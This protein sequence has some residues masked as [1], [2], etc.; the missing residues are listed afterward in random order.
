MGEPSGGCNLGGAVVTGGM[1]N[2]VPDQTVDLNAEPDFAVT[3]PLRPLALAAAVTLMAYAGATVAVC[4]VTY[5][6]IPTPV[7]TAWT[8]AAG[9]FELAW[10]VLVVTMWLRKPSPR[11]TVQVWASAARFIIIASQ[12]VVALAIWGFFPYLPQAERMMLAGMFVICSPAQIIAAP[13]NVAANR[14]GILASDGS[15]VLWFALHGSGSDPVMDFAMA[16]FAS[17]IG[18]ML[19]ALAGY[20]PGTVAETVSARLAAEQAKAG[21]ERALEAVAEERDAKTRFI[22][23]ASHYLGQPL[24]AASLFFDQTLRAPDPDQRDRAADGVRKAFASADQLISHMLNHLR[25]EADAVD[26]HLTRVALG[27]AM[28]R[29]AAQFGPAASAAGIGIRAV[30]TSKRIRLDR[31]LFERALGNL[32]SNAIAHSGATRIVI[33][34][35]RQGGHVRVW[36]IDNGCGIARV[37]A[38]RIFDDYYRGSDSR[39]AV[40]SGFGLGLSSV[41]RIAKL[42][43]G[44]AGLDERWLNGAGFFFEFPFATRGKEG[45][46]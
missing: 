4:F 20:V 42:M 25:L 36:V 29:I 2:P 1:F 5:P 30:P 22:A 19:F 27:P 38:G 10:G 46:P 17:V 35:R 6:H 23:A 43:D 13:E 45:L 16:G 9:L 15:L 32:V 11:E 33:G 7:F 31:V 26:P 41:R 18:L 3:H 8:I 21:L 37:D 12:I 39:A 34:A 14:F 40:K 24:Q 28:M 44:N